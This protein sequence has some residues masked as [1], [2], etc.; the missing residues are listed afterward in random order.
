[1]KAAGAAASLASPWPVGCSRSRPSS[2]ALR[3][4]G[5]EVMDV[6]GSDGEVEPSAL[7]PKLFLAQ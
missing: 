6:L 7:T 5:G 3:V 4:S 2:V 1:M